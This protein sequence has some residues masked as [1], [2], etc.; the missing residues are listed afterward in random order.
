M[1]NRKM[2]LQVLLSMAL[3]LSLIL[4]ASVLNT[5][6]VMAQGSVPPMV[7]ASRDHTVGLKADGTVVAA[8]WN[9]YGQCEVGDWTDITQV[10]AGCY[11]TVALKSDGTVVS[12]GSPSAYLYTIADWNMGVTQ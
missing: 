12:T 9:D 11:H 10:A 2:L 5:A 4:P 1:K 7:A 8:G 6:S 3:V